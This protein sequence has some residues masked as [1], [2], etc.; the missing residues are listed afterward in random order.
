LK[1]VFQLKDTKKSFD[2]LFE[3]INDKFNLLFENLSENE[4][5]EELML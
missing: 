3:I 5:D 2:E 4:F 1:E